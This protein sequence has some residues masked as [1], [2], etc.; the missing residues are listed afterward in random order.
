MAIGKLCYNLV[1]LEDLV[2]EGISKCDLKTY[3][4]NFEN[5]DIDCAL[6]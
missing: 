6:S 4:N 1:Y 2:F 3:L 5:L